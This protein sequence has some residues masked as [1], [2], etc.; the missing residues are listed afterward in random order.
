MQNGSIEVECTSCLRVSEADSIA[1]ITVGG[2]WACPYCS[3]DTAVPAG[4][5]VGGP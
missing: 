1:A 2:D 4:D 3:G 5:G